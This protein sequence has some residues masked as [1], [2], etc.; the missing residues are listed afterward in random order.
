MDAIDKLLT[1][2]I[3]LCWYGIGIITGYLLHIRRKAKEGK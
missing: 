2:L 3:N 1:L